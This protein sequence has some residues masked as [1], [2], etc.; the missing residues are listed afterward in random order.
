MTKPCKV[1]RL[2]CVAAV[3]FAFPG[4]EIGLA[5]EPGKSCRTGQGERKV[6]REKCGGG[7]LIVP[8]ACFFLETPA[9]Q[10]KVG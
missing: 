4:G 7:S 5:G 8:F 2:A 10:A 9:T 3:S 6:I 1:S